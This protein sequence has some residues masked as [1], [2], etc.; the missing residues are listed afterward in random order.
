VSRPLHALEDGDFT[1][2]LRTVFRLCLPG[3]ERLPL[4]LVEVT[5]HPHLPTGPERRRG[6][7]ILLRS[8][9]PG[10]LPQA[11]YRLEHD[12][13]GDL[14]LFLVPVGARE[15]GVVYEAVFN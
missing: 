6:F 14:E 5:P 4:V 15:G 11:T 10:H 3:G 8:A 12:V 13:M 9:L 1:S 2:H 7:S